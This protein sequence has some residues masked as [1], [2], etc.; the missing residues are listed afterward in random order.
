M[1]ASPFNAPVAAIDWPQALRD[2][3]S[4]IRKVVQARLRRTQ[5]VEDVVQEISAAVLRQGARPEDPKRV[6][7]WL[8]GVATRQTSQFLRKEGRQERLQADYAAR[9]EAPDDLANPRDWVM[10][11][12]DAR[13]VHR[14][15]EELPE[16]SREL[17]L[18]KYTED[19]TYG[20]LA[21]LLGVTEKVIEHRLLKARQALRFQLQQTPS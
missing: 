7:P 20:Q 8:Y 13:S 11:H 2:H 21:T 10:R 12:E 19:L 14:A 17:L 5:D 15:L 3:G 9:R 6:A 16:A 1:D 18:L 4:W